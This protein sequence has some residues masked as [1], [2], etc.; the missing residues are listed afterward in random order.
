M[1]DRTDHN[2]LAEMMTSRLGIGGNHPPEP[3]DIPA[4]KPLSPIRSTAQLAMMTKAAAD[5]AYAKSRGITQ[6]VA[7]AMLDDHKAAGEP[8]L[9]DRVETA[10][11]ASKPHPAASLMDMAR[12]AMTRL[13][14]FLKDH[15]VIQTAEDA[16]AAKIVKDATDGTL[17][18]LEDERTALVRPLNDKVAEINTRYKAIH[19]TDTKRPGSAD[20]LVNELKS[21]VKVFLDAEEARRAA[22]EQ[23]ANEARAALEAKARAAEAAEREAIDNA[24]L[25]DC[26]ADVAAASLAADE[27]FDEFARADRAAAR[28]ERDTHVKIGGGI[29]NAL[30]LRNKEVLSVTDWKAAI[31]AMGLTDAIREAILTSARAYR[32]NFDELPDGIAV[33]HDRT[34]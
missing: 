27:A 34:I 8:A 10:P 6:A 32:K 17:K 23:A 9:P 24:S 26:D 7:Q 5:P 12:A 25:G 15:P 4:V 18:D 11:T 19:N 29:A 3:I 1:L 13:G 31:E 21:R 20:K 30:S 28:A 33:D 2:R 22:V 14:A 16:R